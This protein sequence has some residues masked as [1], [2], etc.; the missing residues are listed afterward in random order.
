VLKESGPLGTLL[1]AKRVGKM[2]TSEVNP[3]LYAL[4][5]DNLVMKVSSQPPVWSLA[6][7]TVQQ[8]VIVSQPS[9]VVDLSDDET[10]V[11]TVVDDSSDNQDQLLSVVPSGVVQSLNEEIVKANASIEGEDVAYNDAPAMYDIVGSGQKPSFTIFDDRVGAIGVVVRGFFETYCSHDALNCG[12]GKCVN[13]DQLGIL[14]DFGADI[15]ININYRT[16]A[17]SLVRQIFL[18][19]D[20]WKDS[21]FTNW[22]NS[23]FRHGH[24]YCGNQHPY[25]KLLRYLPT[26]INGN[27]LDYGSGSGCGAVQVAR[28]LYVPAEFVFC[29]DNV[30]RLLACNR[31]K[32]SFVTF[33]NFLERKYDLITVNNVLHHVSA[34]ISGVLDLLC[35]VIAPGGRIVIKDHKFGLRNLVNVLAIHGAYEVSSGE[36]SPVGERIYLR[37]HFKIAQYLNVRNFLIECYEIEESDVGDYVLVCTKY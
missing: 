28:A 21:S 9:L 24:R 1:L 4:L 16:S 7:A 37:N 29:Y 10:P 25:T 34:N 6:Q 33:A 2:T 26:T 27:Y 32:V 22:L 12:N 5:K 15:S 30:D 8:V 17:A 14:T 23:A 18:Q 20:F 13:I 31:S 11:F 19:R 36:A 3:T 35:S